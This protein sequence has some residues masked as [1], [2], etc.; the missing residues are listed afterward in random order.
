MRTASTAACGAA[1]SPGQEYI[2]DV[3]TLAY[4][5]PA[6]SGLQCG[7]L[8]CHECWDM[9]LKV[10]VV[11]E[12]RAQTISCPASARDIVVDETTVLELL[13]DPEV[14]QKYQHLITNSFVLDN[15]NLVWCPKPG[16]PNAVLASKLEYY[17]VQCD[18]G[19]A[20]CFRCGRDPHLP[21]LCKHLDLWLKKCDDDSETSNWIHV[22]TKECYRCHATIEKNGGC[23]HMVCTTC[24]AEFCWTCLGPWEPHGSS[25]YHC[26]RFNESD[27]QQ[28]RGAQAKS[29]AALERYLFYFNRYANHLR[30][31]KMEHK[32]Y[33]MA[34]H[35][36]CELQQLSMSWIEAQ[37]LKKA[38][39]VLCQCRQTLRYTYAFAYYLKKNNHTQIFE[40]NQRDL[41][42]AT[43]KL[44]EYLERDISCSS[45]A[46][47]KVF[48]QDKSR[49]CESRCQA[50]LD[51]VFEGYDLDLWE[52]IE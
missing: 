2:C 41:E 19:H 39:D 24:K 37:F 12:G 11:C 21:I 31:S 29:R 3:C 30:S 15:P 13:R 23:N 44:S 34:H 36:M 1:A 16:C 7:H 18:C 33:D 22:N 51:H 47:M 8:F 26:N 4:P 5:L 32:L 45:V 40:D 27:S 14:R 48:V 20:F 46:D 50:L 52:F 17:P 25:W 10:M 28:A 49:Y 35:K 38:V 42:M 43:E 9:Y 6:M